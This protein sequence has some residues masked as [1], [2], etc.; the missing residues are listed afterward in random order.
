LAV[1]LI[2]IGSACPIHA[3]EMVAGVPQGGVEYAGY[4][5]SL[6]YSDAE[7]SQ[8]AML[9]GEGEASATDAVAESC[10][11][12]ACVK[13]CC[14][15]CW[16]FYGEFLYLR[17]GN[18]KVSY[19]VP[20]NGA[21]VPPAGVAP[22]QVGTEGIVDN[23]FQ[24]GFRVGFGRDLS[25]CSN[26]GG[27]YTFYESNT[28]DSTVRTAPY[29][30]RSLAFHPGTANASTDFLQADA[31]YSIDFQMVDLEFRRILGSGDSYALRYVIGARYGQ[32]EQ[33][34]QSVFTNS[35]VTELIATD[36][37]FYGAGIR[38]GLEG[39]RRAKCNGFL[40]YAKGN[41]S[42]LGGEVTGR[43]VQGDAFGGTVVNTGW[44]DDRVI[45]I[46]DAELG[47]GWV[48]CNGRLR[49][50]AGY[51]V[52]AW[53]NAVTTDDFIRSVQNN[54]STDVS[55]TL[56]FDGLTTRMELRY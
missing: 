10:L 39:E 38:F 2:L 53:G 41:A 56:T 28:T 36:V 42:F 5:G 29:V 40:V 31:T 13:D 55:D 35:T 9:Y 34:F 45:S 27:A 4:A 16:Q 22:V 32:L 37:N 50:T 15:P 43:Y 48:G 26:I 51:L 52:S 33:G 47:V 11:G 49:L 23:D 1:L 25:E 8:T 6:G 24:P 44:A 19:A 21:I 7:V 46:I 17:P 3:Q 20:I 12:D 14:R 30:L 54:N 18:D